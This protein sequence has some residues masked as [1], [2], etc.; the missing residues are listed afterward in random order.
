MKKIKLLLADD[1]TLVRE[2]ICT[3]LSDY[4]EF[5]IVGTVSDGRAVINKLS[6]TKPDIIL[7][8]ISM[9]ELNGLPALREIRK[10][11]NK[12]K[13]VFLTM[14]KNEEYILEALKNGANGYLLKQ[15]ETEELVKALKTVHSGKIYLSPDISANVANLIVHSSDSPEKEILTGKEKEVLKLLGEGNSV[16]DIAGKMFI[17]KRTVETHK[18]NIMEKMDLNSIA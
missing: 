6:E 9:P 8:D 17:S 10:S 15:N 4:E 3:I 2:G 12:V 1:H 5:E 16:P 7:L 11:G 18:R 14:H 13:I